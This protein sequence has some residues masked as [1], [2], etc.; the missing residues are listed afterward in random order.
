MIEILSSVL[1]GAMF[2]TGVSSMFTNFEQS[3]GNGHFF[4]AIDIS[5]FLEMDTYYERM[6]ELMNLVKESAIGDGKVMIPG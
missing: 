1:T 2:S 3:G 5:R 6:E 4:I